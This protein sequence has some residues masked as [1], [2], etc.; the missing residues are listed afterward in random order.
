[1]PRLLQKQF[2]VCVTTNGQKRKKKQGD[3]NGETLILH[4]SQPLMQYDFWF[5]CLVFVSRPTCDSLM[6]TQYSQYNH[7]VAQ[8]NH[9]RNQTQQHVGQKGKLFESS[10]CLLHLIPQKIW[11]CEFLAALSCYLKENKQKKLFI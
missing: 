6:E 2:V 10:C 9:K 11:I 1:M 5:S 4:D 8:T 3:R 7:T